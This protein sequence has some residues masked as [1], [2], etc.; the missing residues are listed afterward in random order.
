MSEVPQLDFFQE[1]CFGVLVA[2]CSDDA[3]AD[4]AGCIASK[5]RAV[6]N[7][8]D[9]AAVSCCGNCSANACDSASGH[10]DVSLEFLVVDGL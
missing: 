7:Q 6:L 8:D 1:S 9:R 5:Y 2:F 10:D 3:H 4:F